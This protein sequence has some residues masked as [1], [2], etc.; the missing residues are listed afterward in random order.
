M[1]TWASTAAATNSSQYGVKGKSILAEYIDFPQ[2]VP[3]DYM[4]SILEGVFKQLMKL[5]FS[6]NFYQE[7]YS[8][9]KNIGIIDKLISTWREDIS[10]SRASSLQY[11]RKL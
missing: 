3:V 10:G 1:K 4:H 5:W 7:P 8:L 2:C 9:R 6:P 11:N